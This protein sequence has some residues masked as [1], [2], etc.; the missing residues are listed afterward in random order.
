VLSQLIHLFDFVKQSVQIFSLQSSQKKKVLQFS[1]RI[2]LKQLSQQNNV[3]CLDI[4]LF[5]A[6]PTAFLFIFDL[7][8]NDIV[9]ILI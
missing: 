2:E 4:P 3:S 5:G 8:D 9:S 6:I 1:L 7:G